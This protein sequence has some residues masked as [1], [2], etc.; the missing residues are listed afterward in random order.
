MYLNN[1]RAMESKSWTE[2]LG[3]FQR[4]N[5]IHNKVLDE[6]GTNLMDEVIENYL[7]TGGNITGRERVSIIISMQLQRDTSRKIF[8]HTRCRFLFIR[9]TTIS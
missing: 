6:T 8:W 3:V 5:R 9:M 4:M 7:K 2:K 1:G